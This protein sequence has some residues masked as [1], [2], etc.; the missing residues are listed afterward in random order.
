MVKGYI[1]EEDIPIMN[2]Y[3]LNIGASRYLQQMLTDI[4]EES[5]ETAIIVG[6]FNTLLAST[7][8]FSRQNINKATEILNDTVE[9][10]DF[11]D[12]FRTLHLKKN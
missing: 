9:K 5:Y 4:K 7:D 6:D 11:I 2:R 12:I 3:A 10:L 1:Q 8:R